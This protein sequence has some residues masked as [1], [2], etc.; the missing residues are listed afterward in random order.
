MIKT[1][2]WKLILS[3]IATLLP[4]LIG[5]IFWND[6]PVQ[7]TTH[8]GFDGNADGWS[9]KTFVVFGLPLTMLAIHWICIFFTAKDP[10][11][12]NQNQKVFGMVLWISPILSFFVN[13][14][15]YADA[16]GKEFKIEVITLLL[17]GLMFVIIGNYLPKCK[18]NYTIGIKVTWALENEENWN[19]THRLGGKVW[20]I[21]GLLLM[22]CV[23][24]P[25]A[26]VSWAL[27]IILPVMAAIPIIYSY[28]YYRKQLKK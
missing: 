27:L 22:A 28:V 1:N 11:N 4:V 17:I 21:G 15:I 2:K 6:L 24:L 18:Q 26:A 3:S 20:V 14:I 10:K 9:S 12:K 7:M 23:F 19:A 25:E 13:G 16:F 5:V 8:W